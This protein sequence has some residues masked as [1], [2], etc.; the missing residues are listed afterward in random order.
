MANVFFYRAIAWLLSALITAGLPVRLRG[1]ALNGS[2]TVTAHSGCMDC[3]ANSTEAMEAG[4]GAGAQIVEF[5]LHF[6]A[7]GSPVLSH[8][9]PSEGQNCVPLADAFRFLSEHKEI[10]ANVD[11]K[12]TE[13]LETLPPLAEEFG[14]ADQLFITGLREKDIP[15]AKEKCPGIPY[16]LNVSV[17]E[18]T[19]LR[20]LAAKTSELGAVGVNL[21][22][23]GASR[24][25]VRICHR[26]GLL[27][28]VWTV[29][30]TQPIIEMIL[31][32]A[33]NITSLRPDI[34]CSVMITKRLSE[35]KP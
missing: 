18:D 26:A 7:D 33:D 12:S 8:D 31:I 32:G 14:V 22:W 16:Y 10:K 30:E 9:A 6:T 17:G 20:A 1:R 21:N 23:E 3:A 27:V 4:V 29:N 15:A 2:V 28:S 13:H 25:L 19:D 5:D 34:A 11:V 24:K 35:M